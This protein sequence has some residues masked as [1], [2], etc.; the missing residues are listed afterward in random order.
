MLRAMEHPLVDAIGHPTGRLIERR[1]P[2][3]LDLDRVIAKAVETGT[4]LEINA[5]P[6]RRDLNDVYARAAAEAGVTLV[7]DSDAHGRAR[8]RTCATAWPPR[9]APGSRRSRWRT[10]AP[11]PSCG[12]CA[13]CAPQARS[14]SQANARVPSARLATAY[15]GSARLDRRSPAAAAAS[16]RRTAS[17]GRTRT[18]RRRGPRLPPPRSTGA[19]TAAPRAGR[20][21]WPPPGTCGT[22]KPTA[23]AR[24]VSTASGQSRL[25]ITAPGSSSG[26]GW[27]LRASAS[28]PAMPAVVARAGGRARARRAPRGTT[29]WPPRRRACCCP[30]AWRPPPRPPR[31]RW[32][33]RRTAAPTRAGSPGTSRRVQL[34]EH[35]LE[36]LD[37]VHHEVGLL[38]DLRRPLV[39]AHA[40]AHGGVELALVDE[41][42]RARRSR[43]GRS[44]RRR[45]TGRCAPP[46]RSTRSRT[47]WPLSTGTGGRISSTLRPQ[48]IAQAGGLGLLGEP[49]AGGCAPLSSSGAPRQ[50]KV[51]IGP[52][53]SIR[54][55]SERSSACR[56][57]PT[58]RLHLLLPALE[59]RRHARRG[60][61]GLEQL[62][63]VRARVGDAAHAHEAPHVGHRA[64]RDARHAAVAAREPA[65]QPRGL[66]GHVGVLGAL[67]DRGERAVHV[68]EDRRALGVGR[69]GTE[70][71]QHAP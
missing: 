49:L 55:R 17:C 23:P 29:R 33:R 22:K 15:A 6:D 21:R 59:R 37:P 2:Y 67:H 58:K 60:R 56:A 70:G 12:S 43:R 41:R 1:E 27:S 61:A 64:A 25:N 31:A 50:W 66:L 24:T 18:P 38:D 10:R 20:S 69:H 65:E 35:A 62:G 39:R 44:R 52:L 54:I 71:L 46:E 32:P 3:A 19:A 47:A 5:N 57:R 34:R 14:R 45:R 13:S 30:R 4:F 8:S 9:G 68:A 7:I 28:R 63:A 16:A 36:A 11:G 42:S 48:W 53:S 51:M 40:H 26:S